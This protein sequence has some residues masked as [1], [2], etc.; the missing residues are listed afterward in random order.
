MNKLL[1]ATGLVAGLLAGQAL[2]A[3]VKPYVSL[4]GTYSH[5]K[6]NI[7]ATT[8]SMGYKD[9]KS[10]NVWGLTA[11]AGVSVP[12]AGNYVRAE[13]EYGQNRTANKGMVDVSFIDVAYR[14]KTQ[15][16]LFNGYYDFET[17]TRL[18]PY[19][20]AGFGWANTKGRV[21]EDNSDN[22]KFDNWAFAWQVGA[23]TTYELTENL[24]LD[25]G[26]RFMKYGYAKNNVSAAG[27]PDRMYR[28]RPQAHQV[29]FGLRYMF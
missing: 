17:C 21:I 16:I 23:G 7:F 26:Y 19:V 29:Q 3:D 22:V 24:A 9:T 15:S 18:V 14:L 10:D 25:F 28:I 20:G 27:V 13:L 1:I 2:A 11:A 4:K 6:T 5:M 8:G 12:V